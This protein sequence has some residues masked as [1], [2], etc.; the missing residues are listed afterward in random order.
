[1]HCC[2]F[3]KAVLGKASYDIVFLIHSIFAFKNKGIAKKILALRRPGGT[4]VVVSNAVD[5]FLGGLKRLVDSGYSDKRFEIDDLKRTLRKLGVRYKQNSFFTEWAIDRRN[6]GKDMG[7][8]LKWISLGKYDSF[9]VTKRRRIEAYTSR[10]GK[11]IGSAILFREK[12]VV[13]TI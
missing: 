4:I 5:G 11:A 10:C 7:I 3:E 2:S 6:I 12:E 13:L 8:I 9:S 1:M